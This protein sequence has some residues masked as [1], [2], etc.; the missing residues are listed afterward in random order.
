MQQFLSYAT[1]HVFLVVGTAVMAI[2]VLVHEWRTRAAS[3]GALS[4]SEVVRLVNGGALLIDVRGSDAF[5]AGHI[6]HARSVPGATIAE[7]AATLERFKEK[8]I[9][10]YCDSG[11]TSSIAVRHLGRLGFAQVYNLRGGLAAWRADNL[12]VEKG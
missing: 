12:P 1:N 9:V 11:Q 7:G 6:P 8:A 4:P 10:A 3:L 2:V 5:A